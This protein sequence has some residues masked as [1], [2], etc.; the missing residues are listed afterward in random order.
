MLSLEKQNSPAVIAEL[1]FIDNLN[2]L[3]AFNEEHE[4]K[5][6]SG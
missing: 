1:G 5:K 4:F 2:D 6:R 3:Q